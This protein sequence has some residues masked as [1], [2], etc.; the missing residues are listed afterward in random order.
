[1]PGKRKQEGYL[2]LDH[3]NSPGV[4]DEM[5]VSVGLGPGAGHGVYESPTVTCCHCNTVVILNPMRTRA[6]GY[7]PKCDAYV[8]DNPACSAECRPFVKQLDDLQALIEK[9]AH[10]LGG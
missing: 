6:R 3:R 5:M 2:L 8:C 1:M 7:C 9:G 4:P 10:L